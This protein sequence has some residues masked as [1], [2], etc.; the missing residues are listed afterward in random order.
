MTPFVP[1]Q[2]GEVA[3][4]YYN[5]LAARAGKPPV[6]AAV[7]VTRY[8]ELL[9]LCSRD[10]ERFA[11]KAGLAANASTFP[12]L[13]HLA[14]SASTLGEVIMLVTRY[15]NLNHDLGWSTLE[16]EGNAVSYCWHPNPRFLA[17]TADPLYARLVLCVFSGII[18]FSR[19]LFEKPVPVLRMEIAGEAPGWSLG[20]WQAIQSSLGV[21]P[22]FG[23]AE[24]RLSL[25]ARVLDWPVLTHDPVTLAVL[26]QEAEAQWLSR[27]EDPARQLLAAL[28]AVLL[29]QLEEG[30]LS[31]ESTARHLNMSA[32]TLQRRLSTLQTSWQQEVTRLRQQ[33]ALSYL[34]LPRLSIGEI[35]GRLGYS[36][37]SAFNHAFHEWFRTSP[38]QWREQMQAESWR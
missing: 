7:P 3:A 30:A 6:R 14:M 11:L 24:N 22:V 21:G 17:S 19:Q 29:R 34:R 28:G 18:H 23:A 35:A 36:D 25:P 1:V 5:T 26:R 33:L 37:Q 10:D 13:G 15:E 8:L 38:G 27:D 20:L 4:G 16:R 31:L 32:R 9:D 12:L 2:P